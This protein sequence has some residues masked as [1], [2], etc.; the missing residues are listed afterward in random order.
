MEDNSIEAFC[1]PFPPSASP[2]SR[3]ANIVPIL[4]KIGSIKNSNNHKGCMRE[5]NSKR[6]SKTLPKY[7][8]KEEITNILDKAKKH[9]YRNYILLLALWRTGMRVSEIV[10]LKKQDIRSN[11]II[12]RQAKGKKDRIVPLESE[13]GNLLGLYSDQMKPRGTLFNLSTRQ[14]RNIIYRYAPKELDVHPH[15]FRHS[16]AV[17]CLKNGMNVRTLQKILGHS[18]LTTT[19]VYLD[20]VG[21]DLIDEFKKVKWD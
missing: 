19:A 20:V 6:A 15:T 1:L 14:V 3:K 9:R 4:P 13:L 12:I 21:A 8:S 17:H 2:L 10:K 16:Y 7:I 5:N 11:T 18:D